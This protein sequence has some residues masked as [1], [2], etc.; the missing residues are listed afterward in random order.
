MAS[1]ATS[2]IRGPS[3][4]RVSLGESAKRP[5]AISRSSTRHTI[6]WAVDSCKAYS[7]AM[8]NRVRYSRQYESASS[9]W[10]GS[11][12]LLGRPGFLPASACSRTSSIAW[13]VGLGTPQKRRKAASS[14]ALSCS[15][16][17]RSRCGRSGLLQEV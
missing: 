4:T 6:R 3:S 16:S 7:A 5:E 10:S 15:C 1:S 12:S 17:I 9:S 2:A 11:E 13:K 8:W 14:R